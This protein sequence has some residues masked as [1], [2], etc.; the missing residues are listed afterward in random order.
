MEQYHSGSGRYWCCTPLASR[1]M[2]FQDDL[3]DEVDAFLTDTWTTREGQKVPETEDVQLGNDAVK[4]D[5]VVLYSDMDGSTKLVDKYKRWF[6]T[7]IY[8]SFLYTAA[9]VIRK[10]GGV[11]TSFDGDRIM[12]VFIG[13]AKNTSAARSALGINWARHRVINQ[14]IEDNYPDVDYRSSH[15][16]GVASSDLFIARTGI[17][18]SN[19]LVWV[20]PAANRAA[21][22]S[23]SGSYAPSIIT[24]DVYG[25]LNDSAKISNDGEDMWSRTT[26]GEGAV[27]TSTWWKTP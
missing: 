16:T 21:Q 7:S 12:A 18:G 15:T 4:L 6:A 8:K 10:Q 3:R 25:R 5:A 23:E 24:R 13:N 17:R 2:G 27:Y 14:S 20:G 26:S 19:D 9:K 11:I 22:L 1:T